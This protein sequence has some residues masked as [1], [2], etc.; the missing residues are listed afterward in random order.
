MN[1]GRDGAIR[2]EREI[3]QAARRAT[4]V[5]EAVFLVR[6]GLGLAHTTFHMNVSGVGPLDYPFLRT[7]YPP[8]W[9]ARYVLRAYLNLDPTIRE[10]FASTH[11]IMWH[12]LVMN[13]REKEFMADARAH[14][15]GTYGCSIPTIDRFSRR[16]LLSMSANLE[17]DA[18]IDFIGR[19]GSAATEVAQILHAKAIEELS[20]AAP[21]GAALAPRE[22][23]CLLWT[24]RGKD[25]KDIAGI[26]KLSEYTV[27]SYLRTARQKLKCRNLSQAVA[28]AVHKRIIAP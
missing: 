2:P 3:I 19:F 23:E 14:G 5:E 21:L 10:G 6:D 20:L 9:I 8:E 1:H 12:D 7:T 18:W 17:L 11:P 4:S 26:L 28:K 13:E 25:S 24:A 15:I 22:V 16:S 27:R